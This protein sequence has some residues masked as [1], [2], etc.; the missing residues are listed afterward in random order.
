[1]GTKM[2]KMSDERPFTL[3]SSQL[4]TDATAMLVALK[5]HI[6][7]STKKET[8]SNLTVNHYLLYQERES[9]FDFDWYQTETQD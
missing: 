9:V 4:N 6:L 1:M 7:K 8:Y 2:S 3:R 5:V